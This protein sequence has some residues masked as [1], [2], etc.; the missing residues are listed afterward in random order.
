MIECKYCGKSFNQIQLHI[1][2]KHLDKVEPKTFNE[3][4]HFIERLNKYENKL[5]DKKYRIISQIDSLND[6]KDKIK[7]QFKKKIEEII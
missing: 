6:I 7:E 1:T 4:Y 2:L 5:Q 3:L